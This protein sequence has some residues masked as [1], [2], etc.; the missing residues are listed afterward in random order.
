MRLRD[1]C[2]GLALIAA[3]PGLL[4]GCGT[5]QSADQLNATL[6]P[7]V[8]IQITRLR[9][10]MARPHTFVVFEGPVGYVQCIPDKQS[11]EIFC[12]AQSVESYEGLRPVLT[13]ERVAILHKLGY[14]DPGDNSPNYG[15]EHPLKQYSD[16]AI[17]HEVLLILHDVY[18]YVGTPR[19]KIRT[20]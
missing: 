19:L 7:T 20:K 4:A 2:I 13:P 8:S 17:A 9:A 1:S 14:A 3:L 12:E 5:I 15:K 18:G 16:D 10:E 6:G 11:A